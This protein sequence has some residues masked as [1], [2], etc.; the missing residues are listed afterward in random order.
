MNVAPRH[1]L[2]MRKAND[3]FVIAIET[4]RDI[5]FGTCRVTAVVFSSEGEAFGWIRGLA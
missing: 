4:R 2:A 5:K 3:M 1:H